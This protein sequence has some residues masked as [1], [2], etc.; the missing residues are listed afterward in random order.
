MVPSTLTYPVL[1]YGIYLV[2]DYYS[3][4]PEGTQVSVHIYTMHRD[5]REFSPLPDTF[6][7]DRWLAGAKEGVVTDRSAFI[8]FST[9]SAGCVGKP[10][11]LVE[12]RVVVA[13]LVQTFDMRFAPG[14]D[15]KQ[16]EEDFHDYFVARKGELP[17]VLS[18]RALGS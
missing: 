16:W 2:L 6:W 4:V 11:A 10:L 15:A 13:L 12:L 18:C 5:S 7:P 17:V 9:G 1:L 3:F 14:Y 8:P